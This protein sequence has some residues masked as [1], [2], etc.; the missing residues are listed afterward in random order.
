MNDTMLVFAAR[1]SHSRNTGAS[2]MV[3]SEIMARWNEL[4]SHTQ[5]QLVRESHEAAYSL[6]LWEG[7]RAFAKENR[8]N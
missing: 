1:Y 4:S 7:F 6:E 8:C 5:D 2:L 3:V